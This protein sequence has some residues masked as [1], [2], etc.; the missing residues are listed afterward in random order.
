[1]AAIAVYGIGIGVE[2]M[3]AWGLGI[4]ATLALAFGWKKAET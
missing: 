4:G 3:L 2:T 1:M